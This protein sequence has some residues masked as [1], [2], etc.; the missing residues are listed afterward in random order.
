MEVEVLKY[1]IT[2]S[3]DQIGSTGK[4]QIV[5]TINPHSYCVARKD[6]VFKKALLE[7]TILL[8]DGIG[9]VIA[10]KF[11]KGKRIQKIAGADL[12]QFCL[13]KA[14]SE[15]KRVFYLGASQNTL[16]KIK[17][18]LSKEYPNLIVDSYSPPYKP[19]FSEAENLEMIQKVNAFTPDFL[20]VGMTAPKQEKWVF[21]HQDKLQSGVICSIGAVFD[22]YAGTVKRPH[23]FWI[24]IGLEWFVRFIKEPKRLARRNLISM[25]E[26]IW[27]VI[28][29]KFKKKN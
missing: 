20:F 25:P 8:P 27:Y 2:T 22:F 24:K 10:A 5:N 4:K 6:A 17:E 9:I 7:S 26:F 19:S 13:D 18:R 14:N 16:N 11:L 1:K 12:H 23:P 29:E 28:K 3:L 15:G 21:E